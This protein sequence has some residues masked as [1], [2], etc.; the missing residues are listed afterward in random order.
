[1]GAPVWFGREANAVFLVASEGIIVAIGIAILC[2]RLYDIDIIIN[3]T[4]VYGPLTV[5]LVALYFGGVV[6]LQRLFVSLTGE[7]ATLVVVASTLLIAALFNP[8]RRRIQSFIVIA[9]TEAN[10]TRPKRSK[11]SRR[12]CATKRIWTR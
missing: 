10:T 2:Y 12:S 6:S 1:M 4:L 3:R 7:K 5:A 11:G 9:F 8:L